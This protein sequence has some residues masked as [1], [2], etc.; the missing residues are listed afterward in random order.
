MITPSSPS[1]YKNR[2]YTLYK[3]KAHN[4]SIEIKVDLPF[5]VEYDSEGKG[6]IKTVYTIEELEKLLLD[7][8]NEQETDHTDELM[9]CVKKLTQTLFKEQSW[10]KATPPYGTVHGCPPLRGGPDRH[11]LS[12]KGPKELY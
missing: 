8:V 6:V 4:E 11:V 10:Q 12:A 2:T 1:I 7:L 3:D 5:F 9:K